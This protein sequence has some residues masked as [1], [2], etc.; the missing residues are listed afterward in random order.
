MPPNEEAAA[1]AANARD[2]K[3][4]QAIRRRQDS[5]DSLAELYRQRDALAGRPLPGTLPPNVASNPAALDNDI[6]TAQA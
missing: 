6:G 3:V 1:L 4:A 2:P 5:A